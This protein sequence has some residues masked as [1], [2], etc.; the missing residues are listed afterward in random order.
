MKLL[1]CLLS[2]WLLLQA[3]SGMYLSPPNGSLSINSHYDY[4]I[5]GSGIG[6]SVI[7]NRLS[8]DT[9]VSVLLIEAGDLD[10]RGEDITVPATIGQEDP[11]RY[12][13]NMS[14]IPQEHLHDAIRTFHQGKV[15]GG[16]TIIN[17]L[18]WTRGSAW[19]YDA[20]KNLGNPGW[21]WKDM[22]PYFTKSEN[23]TSADNMLIQPDSAPVDVAALHGKGGPVDV[24]FPQ[25]IYNQSY[26]F[27]NGMR[28]LGIYLKGASFIPSSLAPGSRH[29]ARTAYLDP[30]S[31]RSN[32]HILTGH[33]VTRVLHTARN[34]TSPSLARLPGGGEGKMVMTGVEFAEN[35]TTP[36]YNV[37]C[38]REVI[39]AAG[40]IFSPILL[41]ISGIGPAELLRKL[42][43][44]VIVNLP[45]VGSNLQDHPMI[46]PIYEFTAPEIFS[47]W[48]IVGNR[49]GPWTAPMVNTVAFLAL[50][51]IPANTSEIISLI[52]NTTYEHLPHTYEASLR[53]GYLAQKSE[54]LALMSHPGVASQELMSTS[55]GQLAVSVMHSLSRGTVAARS[56]FIFDNEPPIIDP[57][58]CSHKLDCEILLA[59]L[60]FN[61]RLIETEPMAV[62]QPK[63]PQGLDT[64]SL[65]NA[66]A[67]V[68]LIKDMLTTEFHVSGT[69]A[70]MPR[71]KGGVVN[72]ELKVY[73]TR[74]LRVVDASIIPLLPGAHIQAAIYAIA[75]KVCLLAWPQ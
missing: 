21:G 67:V 56:S 8:E 46:Q 2:L 4:I 71:D 18:C 34:E 35:A 52:T 3:A 50:E 44:D 29:D 31:S 6:G 40:A 48:D 53:A 24:G 14:T 16:S 58:Y 32:L 19:D 22:V 10:D 68:E 41:Q 39:L 38:T 26:N 47:A 59:G 36:R 23:Y 37:S 12:E 25:Y 30:V 51:D 73:G 66:T 63:P 62:L 72:P 11:G 57:R 17:G 7:A 49:T 9:S 61:A 43:I 15:V 13:W 70:M 74:N 33:T 64:E 20:W 69:A 45:G 28:D 27:L 1:D 5:V 75:E 60:G 42:D 54:T 65:R 55:V